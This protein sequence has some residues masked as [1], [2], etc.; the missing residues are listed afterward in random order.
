MDIVRIWMRAVAAVLLF[1]ASGTVA[2]VCHVDGAAAGVND[3]TSW[4]DAYTSLQSAL[5]NAGCT[6][7]WVAAGTYRP[8]SARSDS[9]VVRPGSA[10][11]GGFAG[12]EAAR[13][14]RDPRAHVVVLSGDIGIAGNASDNS[15]HV[16]T[17]DGTTAAGAI[18]AGTVLDGFTIRDG[19]ANGG[20]PDNMGAGLYCTG[21]VSGR[22]CDPSLAQLRFVANAATYG[23]AIALR[24]DGFG[25]ASPKLAGIV[26]SG[27]SATRLGGAIYVWA[28]LNGI[29]SPVVERATFSGNKA[30]QGGAIYNG[31][32]NQGG[33]ANATIVNATFRGND[34]SIGTSI[35]N[36]GAIYNYGVGGSSNMR[37]TNVTFSGNTANGANHFGGAMV[38][39]G[40]GA[41]PVITN[42]IFRGNQASAM[43]E[44]YTTGGAAPVI[45]ASLV[46][47]GCPSGATCT[48]VQDA[49]PLLGTLADNGGFGQTML[50]GSGSPAIDAGD[51]ASCPATDQRGVPRPQ[52]A[53]CDIG[54]VEV[55]PPHRCYVNRA[56]S[57][58]NDGFAWTSAYTDLQSALREATCNEIWIAKGVYKPTSSTTDRAATFSIRPGLK[59][60]GGFAGNE[61]SAA[62]A[63][64]GA[65]RT[66]LSGD[67]DNNDTVDASGI[68]TTHGNQNGSNS[69]TLV[70]MDGTT[71]AGP[72]GSDTLLDGV[73]ISGGSGNPSTLSGG[74]TGA[75]MY[76]N[77]YGSG[78]ACSPTLTRL[79]FAGNRAD[80]GAGLLN[81]GENGGTSAPTLRSITFS[82][83]RADI[84]GSA[85]MNYAWNGNVSPTVSDVT[86]A[87]NMTNQGTIFNQATA[88]AGVIDQILRGVTFAGNVG[89]QSAAIFGL[90]GAG[91]DSISSTLENT[92][93]WDAGNSPEF[94]ASGGGIRTVVRDSVVR[95]GCANTTGCTAVSDQDPLLG[96]LQGN[97]GATPTMLPG[98]GSSALDAGD[99]ATCGTVPYDFDQRGVARPQGPACDL[100]AVELRQA[101]F[102]VGASG[103]GSVTADAS[104][105]TAASDGIAGCDANGIGCIA[106]YAIEPSAATVMLD[107]A[108]SAHAHLVGV[109]DICGADG[110]SIGVLAGTTYTIAPFN[111]DC[112]AMAIF[113]ADT[114]AVGGQVSGLAGSG[115]SLQLNGSESLAITSDGAFT[116][117]TS[118]AYA[119][120]YTVTVATSPSQPSQT[121][122]V[123]NGSG[124]V[125]DADV[126]DIGV[127]CTT[128]TYT[129]GGSVSGLL[130][131]GLVLQ[132]GSQSLPIAGNGAFVFPTALDSGSDYAV[133][134]ATPPSQPAQVCSIAQGSGSVTDANIG[135][136]AVT[137]A[138]PVPHL[139]LTIDN[140]HDYLR[141]GRVVDYVVTLRNDGDGA[142]AGAVVGSALSA[143]FDTAYAQWQCFGGGGGASCTASGTGALADTATVPPGRSVSW[144][145]SVPVRGDASDADASFAVTVAGATPATVTDTDILVILRDGF[146]VPYGDGTSVVEPESTAILDGDASRTFALPPPGGDRRIEAVLVLRAN[147]GEVRVERMAMGSA[148]TWVRLLR[149]DANGI[150][151]ATAWV[152]ADAGTTLTIGSVGDKGSR[153]VLLEGARVPLQ[154]DG[155][156]Q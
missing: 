132:L 119:A 141:Y 6:E 34:A 140:G 152:A 104:G 156:A 100:G 88:G 79:W 62:Q 40:A 151:R 41:K 93:V 121:C 116:F 2:A 114:H 128:N 45:S 103:P 149:L 76:C 29:A 124:D 144:L 142:A 84:A 49:D 67:I 13:A 17:M 123:T 39:Q 120:N 97:G 21:N 7:T 131:S 64:P 126:T 108:P 75:G 24:A 12:T 148:A 8:G 106:G 80:G 33:S 56:A 134:V 61:T 19:N 60:Y 117:A 111:A 30:D 20:L 137:C 94:A 16:V 52:G 48:G 9:F 18:G 90:A 109:T 135:N 25:S 99:P 71:A 11:Y 15:F 138:A 36:G 91:G 69:Y 101:Q 81:R 153:W 98:I 154:L 47:G 23:G 145:V 68:T 26:F 115:L 89:G 110:T 54:A 4:A 139:V 96:P 127:T 133:T 74:T 57:G 65:Q 102:V 5:R 31:S 95:G 130:G 42:A 22:S 1:A 129:V 86:F 146:D 59:V 155:G 51:D 72:I 73:A 83:N 125:G 113:A 53:H 27:N 136:V 3:G 66:V 82:G 107:L 122:V 37:L 58:A 78:H 105:S 150:E 85:I 70:L 147:G 28:E 10:V 112:A 50:P 14:Q 35:G 92:I 55:V 143:A 63:D 118:L 77:G 38:N 87:N 32:G 44:F 43:P 46:Q